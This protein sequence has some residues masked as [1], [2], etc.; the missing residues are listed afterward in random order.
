[1]VAYLQQTLGLSLN[2]S[3]I[4]RALKK[5]DITRK[6]LVYHYREQ[7]Q[8][9]AQEF[10][11]MTQP[12][13][14]QVPFLALDECSFYLRGENPRFGYSPKGTRA[15]AVRSVK[16]R[17]LYSLILCIENVSQRGVVHQQ[18]VPGK[19][20]AKKLQEFLASNQLTFTEKHYLIWDNAPI[21]H[22]VH[23]LKK[24]GGPTIAEQLVQ[25]NIV[26]WF[27]T[28]YSPKLNPVELCFNFIKQRVRKAQPETWS[29]LELPV[30]KV[31]DLL[32]KMDL[33]KFF[34]HCY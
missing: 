26:P 15:Q 13:L 6:K 18:L 32:N 12:L 7:E 27:I 17:I 31:I 8:E 21:H 3:T 34:Q 14:T 9:K 19:T 2:Q 33:T 4:S 24:A 22:A 29:E 30:N 16:Q 11:K 1:M 20:D 28:P 5:S 10:I 23:V 25:Q